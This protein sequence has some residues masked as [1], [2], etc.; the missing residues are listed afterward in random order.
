[1][2]SCSHKGLAVQHSRAEGL[3]RGV[4]AGELRV[5]MLERMVNSYHLC[6]PP[7]AVSSCKRQG[8]SGAVAGAPQTDE[9]LSAPQPPQAASQPNIR[10]SSISDPLINGSEVLNARRRAGRVRN[11]EEYHGV[12]CSPCCTAATGSTQQTLDPMQ[13]PQ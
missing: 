1:M 13:Q 5:K 11:S 9:T 12:L 10:S 4:P 6:S 3:K 8:S 7:G 2:Y